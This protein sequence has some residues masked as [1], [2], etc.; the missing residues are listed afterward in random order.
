MPAARSP[1]P[2]SD[3]E[4]EYLS[5]SEMHCPYC[6]HT[7]PEHHAEDGCTVCRCSMSW[8]SVLAVNLRLQLA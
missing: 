7:C 4:P 5:T 3:P 6:G 1:R 2:K 8:V